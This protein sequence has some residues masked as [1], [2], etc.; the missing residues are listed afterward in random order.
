M[1]RTLVQILV[2]TLLLLSV[3]TSA[4]ALTGN[5]GNDAEQ[6][7]RATYY[8]LAA[9]KQKEM[10]NYSA[11]ID[12][13]QHCLSIDPHHAAATYDMAITLFP[14]R[15]DSSAVAELRRAVEYDPNN[16]W[17]LETLATA[18]LQMREQD[19]A[20]PIL[21]QMAKLQTKRTDIPAELFQLYKQKGQTDD[22]INA[23]DRIQTLQGNNSRIASQKFALYIDKKD[24][25]QAFNTL[26]QLCR[27]Y[28]YDV[29]CMMILAQQYMDFNMPDSAQAIFQKVER[30][31]PRN[32][33]LQASRLQ[34]YLSVGDTLNYRTQRDSV[35]L[36]NSIDMALREHVLTTMVQ[37]VAADSTQREHCDSIFSR[38]L[39]DEKPP[40]SYLQLYMMYRA[41]AYQESDEKLLPIAERILDVDPSNMQFITTMLQYYLRRNDAKAIKKLCQQSLIYHPAEISF[42]YFLG[43]ACAQLDE[44]NEAKQAL[45][46]AIRQQT[47][48][49]NRQL[50]GDIYGLLGDIY[51]EEG[52]EKEAFQAYDS[53][54]VYTPDNAMCLNN[55]AYYLS[56]KDKQLEQAEEMSYRAIKAAP[57]SKTY[58]DTYAWVLYRLKDYTTARSYMDKVVDPSLPDSTLLADEDISAVLIEHAGD[59]YWHIG[60]EQQ[61]LRLWQLAAQMEKP[62]AT[63]RKKI[64]KRKYITN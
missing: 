47:E 36:D 18:Y 48:E 14:M 8:Y 60:D 25:V 24:T 63:L 39:A 53:C 6:Q 33:L 12:L 1:T 20:I 62:S 34:Y 17:Y 64:K 5:D 26:H 59:I 52:H 50:V 10:G 40:V 44:N 58:L 32:L 35:I 13:L 15:R 61:A 41:Y 38:I 55:Y 19:K 3:A 49:S 23:L 29:S 30:I 37:E 54:L 7:R 28:P 4:T 46:T 43:M 16:P 57:N 51:H 9:Q 22:A 2:C 42:H 56:L 21:E 27:E 31:D 45:T 11:A